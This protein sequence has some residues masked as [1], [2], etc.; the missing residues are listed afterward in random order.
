MHPGRI[1]AGLSALALTAGLAVGS[2]A[3]SPSATAATGD[4]V[5]QIQARDYC[6][7]N[8]NYYPTWGVYNRQGLTNKTNPNPLWFYQDGKVGPNAA[9]SGGNWTT[10][11][12]GVTYCG[13]NFYYSV[14]GKL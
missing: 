10:G 6:S 2:I 14:N 11:G 5:E 1:I 12:K 3:G 13:N 9:K 4:G 7:G 8:I